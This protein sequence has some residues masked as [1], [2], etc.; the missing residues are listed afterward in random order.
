ME[1][2]NKQMKYKL[3]VIDSNRAKL[4]LNIQLVARLKKGLDDVM[5]QD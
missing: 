3:R 4:E 2:P 5:V 1:I